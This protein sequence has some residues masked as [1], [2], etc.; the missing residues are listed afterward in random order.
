MEA[1]CM[2][3][4]ILTMNTD[5]FYKLSWLTDVLVEKVCIVFDRESGCLHVYKMDEIWLCQESGG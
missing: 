1:I 5:H 2:S 4:M 3:H